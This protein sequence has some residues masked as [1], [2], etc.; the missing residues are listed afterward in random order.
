MTCLSY[1]FGY[2]VDV[3]HFNML[4]SHFITEKVIPMSL[5]MCNMM[6]IRVDAMHDL[7]ANYLHA[8]HVAIDQVSTTCIHLMRSILYTFRQRLYIVK[9][10]ERTPLHILYTQILELLGIQ[11]E[12]S[13]FYVGSCNFFHLWTLSVMECLNQMIQTLYWQ[14]EAFGQFQ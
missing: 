8:T 3:R 12:L 11:P 14:I 9:V 6:A 5:R 7:S 1:I 4:S 13:S 2:A 10:Q